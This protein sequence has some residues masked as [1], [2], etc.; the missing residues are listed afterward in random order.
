MPVYFVTGKL[1]SGKT[2]VA[3]GKIRD[4]L[5]AGRR[6][7]TNIDLNLHN[8]PGVGKKAKN[9]RV[10][11]LPDRP[12]PEMLYALGRGNDTRQEEFNGL[13]V[14]D[15]CGTWFNAR[16]WN[17]KKRA[18]VVDWFLHARKLGW[19]IIFLVQNIGIVD[20]QARLAVAEHVVYCRRT[21][22]I[23]IPFIGGLFRLFTGRK[24]PLP[25]VHVGIVKYGDAQHAPTVDR[26]VYTGRDLY[27]SYD[28]NQLFL[29]DYDK[30]SFSYIPPY[31]T[32][33]QFCAKLDLNFIMRMTKIYFKRYNRVFLIASFLALG[34]GIGLLYQFHRAGNVGDKPVGAV[35][36]KEVK[37][38]NVLKLPQLFISSF[39]QAGDRYS[40]QLVS[41]KGD[42]FNPSELTAAGYRVE[43]YSPCYFLIKR[44]E[45]TQ[46]VGCL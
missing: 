40:Y 39:S 6:V 5:I 16:T 22:R 7:A 36:V 19:D 26:W 4:Y 18:D 37:G 15:E 38:G 3:V 8:M 17:D 1:G 14:L 35:A 34:V 2:L 27:A 9:T 45:Y 23:N 46:V 41:K 29:S 13:L 21:D 32:H 42:A 43:I 11:R 24:L 12:T 10:I 20:K 28:T 31:F 44:G 30:G 33:G 25:K